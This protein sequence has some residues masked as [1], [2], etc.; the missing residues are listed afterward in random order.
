[1][2]RAKEPKRVQGERDKGKHMMKIQ[3]ETSEKKRERDRER[4]RDGDRERERES[5]R[6]IE[7]NYVGV[8]NPANSEEKF[9]FGVVLRAQTPESLPRR[10]V[11]SPA[12]CDGCACAPR[13][14]QKQKQKQHRHGTP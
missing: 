12:D 2:K 1:M 9:S 7:Q 8:L 6:E 11:C 14:R 10:E 13:V 4:D 5:E 3:K